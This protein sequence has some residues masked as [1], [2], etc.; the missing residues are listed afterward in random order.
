MFRLTPDADVGGTSRVDSVVLPPAF[1]VERFGPPG[2]GSLD[3][4]VSGCYRFTGPDGAVFTVYDWKETAL[5]L[6]DNSGAPTP[7]EFWADPHPRE[8]NVGGHGED[9]DDGLNRP[10]T[11]FREWLLELYRGYGS[12]NAN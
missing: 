1:L 10:A 6:G 11:A 7:A 5:Y 3:H 2:R 9:N 4:K 8:L 12:R